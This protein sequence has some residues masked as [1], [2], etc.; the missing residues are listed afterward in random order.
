MEKGGG[1]GAVGTGEVSE[2]KINQSLESRGY[3]YLDKAHRG[4]K[5]GPRG[6]WIFL[7]GVYIL[8][9]LSQERK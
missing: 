8:K 4:N 5:L 7:P 6:W 9:F 2:V 1:R 3:F